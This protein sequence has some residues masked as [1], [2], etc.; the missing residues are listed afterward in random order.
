VASSSPPRAAA[1][2]GEAGSGHRN[3][4]GGRIHLLDDVGSCR[5]TTTIGRGW[6][7]GEGGDGGSRKQWC[8]TR[9]GEQQIRR[10]LPPHRHRRWQRGGW[11]R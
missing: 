8:G 9:D 10:L 1:T 6:Q 7:L 5:A 4:E 11:W 2:T 3:D